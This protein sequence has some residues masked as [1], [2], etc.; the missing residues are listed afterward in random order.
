MI[1]QLESLGGG[2]VLDTCKAKA[3]AL[4]DHEI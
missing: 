3:G 4:N 2:G 1:K